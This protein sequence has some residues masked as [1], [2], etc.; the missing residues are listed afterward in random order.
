MKD[1]FLLIFWTQLKE[2][3][4][5]ERQERI[6]P[7]R[8]PLCIHLSLHIS[9]KFA[10]NKIS[11]LY[12]NESPKNLNSPFK[13]YIGTIENISCYPGSFD[14]FVQTCSHTLDP[15]HRKTNSVLRWIMLP[16]SKTSA[17]YFAD[18]DDLSVRL[19]WFVS[20]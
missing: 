5:W 3:L 4:K 16:G 10:N 17:R 13:K 2:T 14:K 6:A 19:I 1:F 12:P 18:A 20:L 15:I 8:W 9:K 11:Y 7:V